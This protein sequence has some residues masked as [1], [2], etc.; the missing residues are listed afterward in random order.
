ML[1]LLDYVFQRRISISLVGVSQVSTRLRLFLQNSEQVADF[2]SLTDPGS[3][4]LKFPT[5]VSECVVMA[6]SF[7]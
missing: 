3:V 2:M 5:C 1:S 6:S 7:L 4:N